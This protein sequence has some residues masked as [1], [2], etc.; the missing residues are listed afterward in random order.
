MTVS[1]AGRLA[2]FTVDD[3]QIVLLGRETIF[4]NGERVGWLTSG[5]FGYTVN[6][7]IGL[8]YVSGEPGV[9][10][11]YLLDGAY[12]LEVAGDLVPC[13]IHLSPLYDPK[14]TRVRS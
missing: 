10:R 5:G 14:M 6:R 13:Q 2:F 11:G 8:G 12:Q 4:R 7:P 9:D 1:F 3:A